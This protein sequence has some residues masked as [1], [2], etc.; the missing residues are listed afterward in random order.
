MGLIQLESG[1]TVGRHSCCSLVGNS[2]LGTP[3]RFWEPTASDSEE[4]T[5]VDVIGEEQITVD[6]SII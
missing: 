6:G 1:P 3:A 4:D 5:A 2:A